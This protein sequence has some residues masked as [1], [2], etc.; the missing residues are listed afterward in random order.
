MPLWGDT[1]YGEGGCHR[2]AAPGQEENRPTHFRSHLWSKTWPKTRMLQ[3]NLV[4]PSWEGRG[5]GGLLGWATVSSTSQRHQLLR[6]R[7][8][9]APVPD[10]LQILFRPRVAKSQDK[11]LWHLLWNCPVSIF[12]AQYKQ[13]VMRYKHALNVNTSLSCT[14]TLRKIRKWLADWTQVTRWVCACTQCPIRMRRLSAISQTP[15]F[16]I[17]SIVLIHPMTRSGSDTVLKLIYNV[18]L[19]VG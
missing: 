17:M 18:K 9:V 6:K 4:R 14:F 19:L 1:K 7:V 8:D 12:R 16:W 5:I 13:D 15:N 11:P 3:A 10:T 2:S